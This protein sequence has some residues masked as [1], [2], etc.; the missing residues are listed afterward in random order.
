MASVRPSKSERP[1]S[2]PSRPISADRL[3]EIAQ[4]FGVLFRRRF[5]PIRR[6]MQPFGDEIELF[7]DLFQRTVGGGLFEVAGFKG[8]ETA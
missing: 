1:A 2:C 3:V 5:P 6:R 4:G 8:G 7:H